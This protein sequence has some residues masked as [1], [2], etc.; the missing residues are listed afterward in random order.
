MDRMREEYG[1]DALT[2]VTGLQFSMPDLIGDVTV[3]DPVYSAPNAT[4]T[5]I[6]R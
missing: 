6:G 1:D 3:I 5:A 4:T 2:E